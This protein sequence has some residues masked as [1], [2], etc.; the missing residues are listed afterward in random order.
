MLWWG[1]SNLTEACAHGFWHLNNRDLTS[2]DHT[3]SA[4]TSMTLLHMVKLVD[5]ITAC[6]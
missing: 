5:G 2:R 3:S 1:F 4:N 6:S